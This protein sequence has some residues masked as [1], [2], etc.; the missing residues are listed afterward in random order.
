VRSAW[1]L[2]ALLTLS[3]RQERASTRE[4]KETKPSARE[5]AAAAT[6]R[7]PI[8]RSDSGFSLPSEREKR[9][10]VGNIDSLSPSEQAAYRLSSDF[11]A[12]PFPSPGD[13]LNEHLEAGQSYDAYVQGGVNRV[14]ERRGT[15]YLLPVGEISHEHAP[16]LKELA[17]FTATFFQIPVD[18]L[19]QIPLESVASGKRQR[20]TGAQYLVQ[21]IFGVLR[22]R[23]P[24]DAYALVALTL[25]DIYPGEDWNFV[26]GQ[27][28]FRERI[29]VHSLARYFP[30]FYGESD[31]KSETLIRR[32]AYK[33]LA[34]EV[35]HTFGLQHCTYFHCIMNGSN[36]MHETDGAPLHLCPVCLRKLQ[37]NAKFDLATRYQATSRHFQKFKLEEE[38][39][40]HAR[41]VQR[42]GLEHESSPQ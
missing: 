26:F 9:R 11:S 22:P 21:S 35:G 8:K 38:A 5:D 13:W 14:S 3:C 20:S 36:G 17:S 29:G 41:R 6:P 18:A 23:V 32:R 10:A 16:T 30:S 34:H 19:P 31:E 4:Q 24:K 27:A 7:A 40:W 28:T 33:V 42:L 12:L 1:I 39:A 25:E 15:I 2:V 37:R